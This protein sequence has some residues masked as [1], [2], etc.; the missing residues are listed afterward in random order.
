MTRGIRQ[1]CPLSPLIFAVVVDILLRRI[2]KILENKGL[3]RAF[4]DDTAAVLKNFFESMPGVAGLFGEYAKISGLYLNYSKTVV[5]PL[6]L[7]Q[8]KDYREVGKLLAGLGKDWEQVLVRSCA[9]YLGFL[10]G[11]GRDDEVWTKTADKWAARSRSW[12]G[13]GGRTTV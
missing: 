6:W 1:G 5:I 11:P 12:G 4:A 3:T 8:E 7:P 10:V 13:V 2:S 9:K